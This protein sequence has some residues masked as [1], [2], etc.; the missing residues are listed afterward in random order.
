MRVY[1]S[2]CISSN[3]EYRCKSMNIARQTHSTFRG[4]RRQ[5]LGFTEEHDSE[6][7]LLYEVKSYILCSSAKG[8]WHRRV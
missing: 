5:L 7:E 6:H 2:Q 8:Q 4:S 1:I 3:P